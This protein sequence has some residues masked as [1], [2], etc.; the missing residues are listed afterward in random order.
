[1]TRN[2]ALPASES[3][4][5]ATHSNQYNTYSFV[6]LGD[7]PALAHPAREVC[8]Q[9]SRHPCESATSAHATCTLPL[10]SEPGLSGP[11]DFALPFVCALL[12]ALALG[13][14]GY[15]M[16]QG[17]RRRRVLCTGAVLLLAWAHAQV[18]DGMRAWQL[19]DH[20]AEV[21]RLND[22]L[23]R[24]GRDYLLVACHGLRP[25]RAIHPLAP[26]EGLAIDL[27]PPPRLDLPEDPPVPP[28]TSRMP[29]IQA[30]RDEL[31]PE[32]IHDRQYHQALAWWQV[33]Q[34]GVVGAAPFAFIEEDLRYTQRGAYSVT[35]RKPWWLAH[36]QQV[37][38]KARDA[39]RMRLDLADDMR[40]LEGPVTGALA[41]Y[42]LAGRDA[43][44]IDDRRH[45]V[46]RLE[47]KVFDRLTGERVW[48]GT[49]LAL[50]LRPAWEP[51][52]TIA[53]QQVET[54][55]DE[56]STTAWNANALH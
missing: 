48:Q 27:S 17:T 31:W 35:A 56:A 32:R 25:H 5:L 20:L 16:R 53:W 55:P 9:G 24:P 38:P 13:R 4:D 11:A 52:G 26:G 41:R 40:S 43:S 51:R 19:R 39:L 1:M 45:W 42:E 47:L 28:D 33:F 49:T 34:A 15:R 8:R 22:A 29:E 36:L 7:V 12:L 50:N 10:A 21:S 37:P 14:A 23:V 2:P 18:V 54:C 30:L 46:A 6:S 44:T 3:I